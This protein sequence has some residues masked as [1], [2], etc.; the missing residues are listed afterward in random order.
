MQSR[1]GCDIGVQCGWA[2][3]A[4]AAAAAGRT[5]SAFTNQ[6]RRGGQCE[7]DHPCGGGGPG[8]CVPCPGVGPAMGT[9]TEIFVPQPYV[10]IAKNPVN[11]VYVYQSN[12]FRDTS[13]T[14]VLSGDSIIKLG[15]L[16]ENNQGSQPRGAE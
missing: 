3:P 14:R 7:G 4:F 8:V 15:E 11:G 9:G 2:D 5:A 1:G 12:L 13:G 10:E 16:G 6:H